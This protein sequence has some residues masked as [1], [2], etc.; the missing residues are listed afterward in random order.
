APPGDWYAIYGRFSLAPL[1]D[2]RFGRFLAIFFLYCMGNLFYMGIVPAYF[3]RDLGLGYV[4]STM[5]VH[6]I[7]AV[8]GFLIGGRLT[9]WFDRTLVWRSYGVVMLLWGLDAVLL[10]LSPSLLVAAIARTSRGPATVG[11][12][13]LSVYTGVHRFARPGPETS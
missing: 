11:S 12:M 5:F 7:P 2:P 4:Q 6:I 9:A 13:V 3:A 1:R 10:A 8:S